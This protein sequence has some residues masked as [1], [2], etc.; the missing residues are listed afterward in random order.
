[1]NKNLVILFSINIII[2]PQVLEEFYYGDVD[3]DGYISINDIVYIFNAID[4]ELSHNFLYNYNNNNLINV[5][6]IFSI[7]TSIF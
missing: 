5:N 4:D 7:F 1:M 6:D 2:S 3:Y